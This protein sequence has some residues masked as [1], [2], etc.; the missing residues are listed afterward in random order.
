MLITRTHF[1]ID[2]LG[3]V[4]V[5]ILAVMAGE[6]ISYVFDIWAAGLPAHKRLMLC[7][8]PCPAC[9]WANEHAVKLL[10]HKERKVQAYVQN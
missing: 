4:A 8:D 7:Y 10:D 2:M 1:F 3:G 9:G 6:K 5:G